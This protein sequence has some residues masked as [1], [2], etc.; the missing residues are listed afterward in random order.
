MTIVEEY[1][2]Y[3]KKYTALY[4]EKTLVLMQV[5]SFFECYALLDERDGTTTT[6]IGSRISDFAKI[7]DMAISRKNICVGS[8]KVVMAGFGLPQ[9]EKY[10]KRLQEHG[11][12]I[13]VFT[14]DNQAKNTTRSLS[15]IYSAGTFFDGENGSVAGLSNNTTCVWIHYSGINN[16]VKRET[17]TIGISN[18]DILTGK[19]C[20]NEFQTEFFNNPTTYDE[21]ERFIS[22]YRP[23]EAILISNLSRTTINS[24]IQY[25]NIR[26]ISKQVHIVELDMTSEASAKATAND[27]HT[28]ANEALNCEKQIYQREIYNK[29]FSRTNNKNNNTAN[30]EI[31]P[32]D[33]LM[34]NYYEYCIAN[35]SLCF[36][37]E[38]IHRHNPM[39]INR[40]ERPVIEN[41]GN[42]LVLAN[43]SLK[44]LNIIADNRYT[45]K[46][47]SVESLLNN[48]ITC[49]GRRRFQYRLLNPITDIEGLNRIYD[50]TEHFLNRE[51]E[52]RYI[53]GR[54]ETVKDLERIKRKLMMG[55]IMP[56]DFYNLSKNTEVIREIYERFSNDPDFISYIGKMGID[57]GF[58]GMAGIMI[59]FIGKNLDLKNAQTVD[60]VSHERL[61]NL[62]LDAVQFIN[63][64]ISA[65][66]DNKT[67]NCIDSREVF[68]AVRN[69]F[70]LQ[71]ETYEKKSPSALRSHSALRT[72]LSSDYIKIH[73]TSK[74]DAVLMGTKR[75]VNILKILVEKMVKQSTTV[76]I[77]Y[78]SKYSN[79][80]E[81][82]CLALDEL[83]YRTHG[84]NQTTMIITS[85]MIAKLSSY[86]QVSRDILTEEIQ[87][88]YSNIVEDF[89]SIVEKTGKNANANANA[90]TLDD[91]VDFVSE[92][93]LIQCRCYIADKYN[94]CRPEIIEDTKAFVHVEK[95]R[96]PLIEHLNM[97][98]LYVAND[99]EL[100]GTQKHNASISRK[101][102]ASIPHKDENEESISRKSGASIP[103][104]DEND[105]SISRKSEASIP[106]KDGMLLYGTNAV[107]KTSFIKSI[108]IAV[109]MAQAGLYV[110]CE[111]FVYHPYH[112]IFTRI[113]GNDNIF[114]GLSTFAVEMSELRTILKQATP[115]S[116]IIGDELCSGTETSSAVS[117]FTAGVE[118]L[119]RI[120][121]TF[122][123]ATHLHEI[124]NYREIQELDRLRVC[125]MSVEF[126]K[127]TNTLIYDRKLREGAGIGMYGLEVCKSLD[128]PYEFL[129]RAH[130][131]RIKYCDNSSSILSA[132]T[133][134]YNAS[135]IKGGLCEICHLNPATEIHHLQE[136]KKANSKGIIDG[137]FHKNHP[138]NLV[139]IC[140]DCHQNIHNDNIHNENANDEKP[141]SKQDNISSNSSSI[142]NSNNIGKK[143]NNPKKNT[144]KKGEHRMGK[145]KTTSGYKIVEIA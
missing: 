91:I 109:I 142:S 125:H 48:A 66:L 144:E 22:I 114:K 53:R 51:N 94:Y 13:V 19:T 30:Q 36:L 44:Q 70:S 116:L 38:F 123:F 8:L 129:D 136:Q 87:K 5:G 32:E 124:V 131:L 45:G 23:S 10:V 2:E 7:N 98:E 1:L 50:I 61:S 88:V 56:R 69:W 68:E 99:L 133:T 113:L 35:Q 119:H 118:W 54:L 73:E 126:D 140:E 92:C 121:A 135:K 81:T 4:G 17:L 31:C 102:G 112:Y 101:S 100:G 74:A 86:I 139:N 107:G 52:W 95:I 77:K 141:Y 12:T 43:H 62:S 28:F 96:H 103:H 29:F 9:L 60:D 16:I 132:T 84:G 25:T 78:I 55:R 24:I 106:H 18:V 128:L 41:L 82:Y 65:D 83:E 37:L 117:I 11:Y 105:E 145:V 90:T 138:A 47:G 34:T 3:T 89:V 134:R 14:Q 26:D 42:R 122:I 67:K 33:E 71:V 15:C 130:S 111:R 120:G 97:N 27:T 58:L 108:G 20:I 143:G 64:G 46:L 80:E 115:N 110:A 127:T 6:Y 93:D 39:L 72:A 59:D 49:M 63:K 104:K 137:S 76:D 40:I 57:T 75:R 21:L 79:S 85:P